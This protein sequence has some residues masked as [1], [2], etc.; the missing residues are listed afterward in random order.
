M[1]ALRTL[2]HYN[3]PQQ[4]DFDNTIVRV[5]LHCFL[6]AGY[7]HR[8]LNAQ[9]FMSLSLIVVISLFHEWIVTFTVVSMPS[10][11]FFGHGDTQNLVSFMKTHMRT[12]T[13]FWIYRTVVYT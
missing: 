3:R 5:G 1:K 8:R 12:M 9:R 7:S 6:T 10:L 2:F 11:L 13:L 4:W